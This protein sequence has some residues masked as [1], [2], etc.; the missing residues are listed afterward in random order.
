LA[1]LSFLGGRSGS[2]SEN[3]IA[4][5]SLD[6]ACNVTG[7]G[8]VA[9]LIGGPVLL[10]AL[11]VLGAPKR[12]LYSVA[13]FLIGITGAMALAVINSPASNERPAASDTAN[14][15][16]VNAAVPGGFYPPAP[17]TAVGMT[18]EWREFADAVDRICA[19][20]YN[21][22]LVLEARVEQVAA[23]RG[24]SDRR[25]QKLRHE[26]WVR[27]GLTI[28]RSTAALGEPP[29]RPDLF[30]RW[31]ANVARRAALQHQAAQRAGEG[32]WNKYRH[33]MNRVYPMK[34]QSD[35]IG[36]SFGLR[37]CTSN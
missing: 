7:Y 5:S 12:A 9:V 6:D 11:G 24:W 17:S 1:A 33:T 28:V 18:P 36:Q 22:A 2:C 20:S 31:R 15:D 3:V 30:T 19:T 29:E 26:A 8:A 13:G 37:I 27:Q 23:A 35:A 34:A 32:R 10:L 25:A 4:H 21:E 16:D 14:A